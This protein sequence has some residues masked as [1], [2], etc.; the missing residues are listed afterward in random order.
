MPITNCNITTDSSGQELALHGSA[1]FPIACYRDDLRISPVPWHWHEELE[2]IIVLR[3]TLRMGTGNRHYTLQQGEGFLVNSGVLHGCWDGGD[4]QIRSIV[5]HPRLMGGAPDSILSA[6][7]QPILERHESGCLS[8]SP[9]I[10]WQK[11]MIA[12]IA[13]IWELIFEARVNYEFPVTQQL[14]QML[15]L[16]H[17]N[18]PLAVTDPGSE[19]RA[20]RL[21]QMLQ[22]IHTN[23][24]QRITV[25]EIARSAAV[26]ESECLRCFRGVIRQTPVQYL[27]QYR[28]RQA[29]RQLLSTQDKI[30]VIAAGCGFED[31][32]FFT[33]TFHKLLGQTPSE[34][35][36]NGIKE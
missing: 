19:R 1:A 26:S 12:C 25:A 35:R 17:A 6:R 30:A 31:V 3:G 5:F 7:L 11:E 34:Y 10:P 28:V 13:D 32:S 33:K 23:Y 16:L 15:W 21:K 36:E 2:A 18:L 24:P 27:R 4:C 29:A 22:F 8:L 9:Q 20:R 14:T